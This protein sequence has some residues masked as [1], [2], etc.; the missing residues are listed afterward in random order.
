[1]ASDKVSRSEKN[2]AE[3]LLDVATHASHLAVELG[4][5]KDVSDQLGSALADH[6]AEHWAGQIITIP[7]D[8]AFKLSERDLKIWEEFDGHN[9]SQLARKYD[10]SVNAIY[11]LLKRTHRRAMSLKQNDMFEC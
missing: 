1:M 4:F 8:Y 6:L 3:L 11:R 2:R 7:R 10:L 5:A 9:H